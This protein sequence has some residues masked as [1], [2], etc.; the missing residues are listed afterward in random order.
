MKV[1]EIMSRGEVVFATPQD[2]I[3][4]LARLFEKG[5]VGAIPVVQE[6]QEK[7]V[8]GIITD[9][10]IV[11]AVVAAGHDPKKSI[12]EQFMTRDPRCIRPEAEV[13][14]AARIMQQTHVRRVP[15]VDGKGALVGMVAQADLARKMPSSE[16]VKDTV[17]K[18]SEPGKGPK[19]GE[20]KRAA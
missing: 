2:T 9:R 18:V 19:K 6:R 16:T 13:G 15:V 1:Q 12:V 17:A 3:E 4:A 7:K 5:D 10:D 11:V 20:E 14:D 8:V